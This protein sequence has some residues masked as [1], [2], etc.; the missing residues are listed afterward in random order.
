VNEAA[1]RNRLELVALLLLALAAVA[2]A[3]SSYQANRWNGEQAK[4]TAK[5]NA[6]RIAAARASGLANAQ[7]QVDI[8]TFTQWVDAYAHEER[9]LTAFYER[10]FRKEFQPAFKAWLAS[11]PLDNPD[12]PLTPFAM[13]QYRLAS[14]AEANRLDAQAE[15]LAAD[16][17]ANI[18]RSSNYVL[19]VV[20]F[21][22]ALF[23]AGVSTKLS[24]PRLRA[25]LLVLGCLI[26]VGTLAWVATSPVSVSV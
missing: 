13:P 21:S 16:A 5:V 19:S 11:R 17:R 23:F 24:T 8:A 9:R 14:T 22:V 6:T 3:W 2:T 1:G 10:R 4:T 20:L 7:T 12:A 18:Q 26:F 15:V 25:A